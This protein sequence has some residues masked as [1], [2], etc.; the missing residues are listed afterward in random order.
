MNIDTFDDK[1]IQKRTVKIFDAIL[2]NINDI[3]Y[4]KKK[5]ERR[6]GFNKHF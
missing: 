4:D 3:A 6:K 2:E 1:R 5:G